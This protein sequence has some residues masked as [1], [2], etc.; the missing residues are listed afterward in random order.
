MEEQA[1]QGSSWCQSSPRGVELRLLSPGARRKSSPPSSLERQSLNHRC[2]TPA[3]LLC[4]E[5]TKLVPASLS[6]GG[7]ARCRGVWNDVV[8]A[9]EGDVSFSHGKSDK[10]D[11]VSYTTSFHHSVYVVCGYSCMP[12]CLGRTS[13]ESVLCLSFQEK[14]S[15]YQQRG[16]S[17]GDVWFP[18]EI[19]Q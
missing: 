8:I 3:I 9:T 12:D 19:W 7:G 4:T 11:I 13:E 17:E 1:L 15:N 2:E 14:L 5:D 10:V 6:P 16:D 18:L